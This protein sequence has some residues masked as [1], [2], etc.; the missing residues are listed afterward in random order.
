MGKNI[1]SLKTAKYPLPKLICLGCLEIHIALSK[2]SIYVRT[3]C[4]GYCVTVV[5]LFLLWTWH[6]EQDEIGKPLLI[7]RQETEWIKW[8]CSFLSIPSILEY[9]HK[10]ASIRQG[11]FIRERHLI[12]FWQFFSNLHCI[13]LVNR[14]VNLM[15][16]QESLWQS[17]IPCI[18][19]FSTYVPPNGWLKSH[20]FLTSGVHAATYFI[21][22]L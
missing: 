22:E 9:S 7:K 6:I 13:I 18:I 11:E 2:P 4:Q 12:Q 8:F 14:S 17:H 5:S 16:N 15:F 3:L 1:G 21:S 20:T 10:R 19:S